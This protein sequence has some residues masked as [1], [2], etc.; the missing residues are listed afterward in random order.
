MPVK[1]SIW[2]KLNAQE[3]TPWRNCY[4][5]YNFPFEQ[6]HFLLLF[7]SLYRYRYS[8]DIKNVGIIFASVINFGEMYDESYLDGKECLRVLNELVSQ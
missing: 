2:I 1:G 8:E 5:Y 4:F 6:S 3:V 7:S